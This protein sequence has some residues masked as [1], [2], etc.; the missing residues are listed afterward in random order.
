MS[1]DFSITDYIVL[2]NAVLDTSFRRLSMQ[3]AMRQNQKTTCRPNGK[4]S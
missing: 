3:H 2:Q 1:D 4:S